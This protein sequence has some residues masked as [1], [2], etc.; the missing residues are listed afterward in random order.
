MNL[1]VT[2]ANGYIGRNLI[3]KASKKGIKIFALTSKKKNRKIKNVTW[4]FGPI[5]KFWKEF[6]LYYSYYYR[7]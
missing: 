4:L 6:G 1:F 7:M 5:D 2:G 3:K